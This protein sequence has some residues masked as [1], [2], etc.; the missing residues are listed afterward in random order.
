MPLALCLGSLACSSE[1]LNSP[2]AEDDGG[3]GGATAGSGGSNAG[4]G[5]AGGSK[6]GGNA[7]GPAVPDYTLSPCYGQPAETHV[8]NLAT[9]DVS[10]VRAT[11]RGE[12]DR[13][14]FY[15]ADDLWETQYAPGATPFSQADVDAFLYAYELKGNE[16]SFRPD[17]G[18]L[19]TDEIV[20]GP[21]EE[22]AL[23]NGK[24]PIFLISSG[25]AGQGYLCS[26]CDTLQLHLDGPLLRTLSSDE[27]LSIAAHESFHAI[28]RGYDADESI[29][30]DETLAEA[31]MTVNG[32]FTDREWL[33]A[34]LHDT[35][36]QWGPGVEAVP[37]FN[38][39]AGLL[40]GTYLW[41]R[42]GED[43]L[44][45]ITAEP[46][47]EWAGIDA[48]LRAL[49]A[50]QDGWQL[51]LDMATAVALDDEASG[52]WFENLDLGDG[53]TTLPVATGASRTE[54]IERYG[55]VYVALG[56]D[57]RGVTVDADASFAARIALTGD[58]IEVIDVPIGE[59]FDFDRP[60]RA[61]VLASKTRESFTLSVR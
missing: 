33:S 51:F 25:G 38:Y 32:F 36:Q 5:G 1:P 44:R 18:V 48:A 28:H 16:R 34:F 41:E 17:L 11:C 53:P 23:T 9:H 26:W 7:G 21:L 50:E 45:A 15:V 8:Y 35:N 46:L 60:A 27:A 42:G 19:P 20:F 12:G 59:A 14:L 47:D 52:Y 56:D 30:V 49:G 57:A 2:A 31:A 22:A 40:F 13:T 24:L 10:T 29:W 43:L 58:P 55:L 54:T 6:A 3:R 37:D 39:G 61:L 4:R